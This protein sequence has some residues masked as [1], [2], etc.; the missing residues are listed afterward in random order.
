MKV[1]VAR[2]PVAPIRVLPG[3]PQSL[4]AGRAVS[5]PGES[6]AAPDGRCFRLLPESR[7][8]PLSQPIF[9]LIASTPP[10]HSAP[11]GLAKLGVYRRGKLVA[12]P[13]L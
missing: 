12:P 4:T 11:G 10:I 5:P 6:K 9:Q 2:G 8:I 7:Q 13:V 1:P 3:R